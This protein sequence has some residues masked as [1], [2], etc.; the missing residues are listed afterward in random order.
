MELFKHLNDKKDNLEFKR[1]VSIFTP[2]DKY[3]GNIEN[4][5]IDTEPLFID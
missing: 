4:G 5:C 1:L 2:D 3:K